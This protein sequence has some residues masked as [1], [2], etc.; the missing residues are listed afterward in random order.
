MDVWK[1]EKSKNR[2]C[3]VRCSSSQLDDGNY[4]G[5]VRI[6]PQSGGERTHNRISMTLICGWAGRAIICVYPIIHGKKM[7]LM[8]YYLRPYAPRMVR[9]TMGLTTFWECI[10]QQLANKK[11]VASWH[12][13]TLAHL[14]CTSDW[15]WNWNCATFS[16][17]INVVWV[18]V[19]KQ[20]ISAASV[21]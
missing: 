5:G 8:K 14:E 3:R 13:T 17:T 19:T 20:N 2:K 18:S 11:N 21:H 16:S 1:E 9:V 15:R 4:T 6:T 10:K 12:M 7:I